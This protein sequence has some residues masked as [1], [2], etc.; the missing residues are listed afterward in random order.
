MAEEVK[1]Y[2]FSISPFTRKVRAALDYKGIKYEYFDEDLNNKSADLL[3]HNPALKLTPV[4]VHNG[5]PVSESLI[6]IQYIDEVWTHKP[7]MPTDPYERAMARFWAHFF[8]DKVRPSIKHATICEHHEFEKAKEEVHGWLTMLENE[9][10]RKGGK[11]FGGEDVGFLD[12]S[13]I[14]LA[15]WVQPM[16][17]ASKREVFHKHKFPLLHAWVDQMR[18]FGFITDNFTTE[19]VYNYY[20][21]KVK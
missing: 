1:L 6:I 10:K 21:V 8:E 12:I 9:L 15:G 18:S 16:Q 13:A 20:I 11:Y 5:K 17:E 2:G 3:K 7:L 19:G 4:L 14:Y